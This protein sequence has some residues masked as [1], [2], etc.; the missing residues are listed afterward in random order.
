MEQEQLTIEETQQ[1]E[2]KLPPKITKENI[3]PKGT[4]KERTLHLIKV[5]LMITLSS[6]LLSFA[7]HYLIAPNNFATGGVSGIA[8]IVEVATKGFIPQSVMTFALNLPLV[9]LSFFFVKRRFAVFTAINI[10]LQ[11]VW[12]VLMENLP[13][14]PIVFEEQP[15]FAA[16]AGGVV[17]GVAIGLALKVGGSTG[18]TDII[19]VIIQRKFQTSSIAWMIF[20]VNCIIIGASLFVFV[21]R[22]GADSIEL[23]IL[24]ILMAAF[25]QFVESKI[26][27]AVT[28]GFHS[29]IEFRV[30]TT[31]PDEMAQEIM[32]RL[33]R[34]V[35]A[36]PAIGMYSHE[37]KSMVV[38]VINRR[39]IAS[40][41]RIL[42]DVD[43]DSFAVMSNVSQVVGLG[44]SSGEI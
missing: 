6:F 9:V 14:P 44:F 25:E 23:K 30:I 33:G 1:T 2:R 20:I 21:D 39:Q 12:L 31:K 26:N 13:F 4:K 7:M 34:G 3:L 43:P 10:G 5:L 15:L 18:G 11:T 8:I 28:N 37:E 35:T 22:P 40:F 29:V 19:A 41:K 24:P 16:I 38:C 32:F 27:D 36:V 42:K 17:I